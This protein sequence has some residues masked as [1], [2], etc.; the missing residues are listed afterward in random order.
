M[1]VITISDKLNV[2]LSCWIRWIQNAKAKCIFYYTGLKNRGKVYNKYN[3]NLFSIYFIVGITTWCSPK[4]PNTRYLFI[5]N[6]NCLHAVLRKTVLKTVSHSRVICVRSV[7]LSSSLLRSSASMHAGRCENP[8]CR[9]ITEYHGICRNITDYGG[10]SRHFPG[11]YLDITIFF[12]G[13]HAT[14]YKHRRLTTYFDYKSD[15]SF[16]FWR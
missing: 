9:N 7:H 12:D 1:V 10:I 5:R 13:S 15:R 3:I 11:I 14:V 8:E 16:P 2:P 6:F 4:T